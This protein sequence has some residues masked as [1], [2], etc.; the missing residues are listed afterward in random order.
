MSQTPS[1]HSNLLSASQN[2]IAAQTR[3]ILLVEDT[4]AHAALIKRAIDKKVWD[5]THVTRGEEAL[6]KYSDDRNCI[7]LLDI[8]LPDYDG[9]TL[10]SHFKSINPYAAVVIVT[11][12]EDVKE[13]V[14]A[15]KSGAW[16][17]VV[18]NDPETFTLDIQKAIDDAWHK[19]IE[20]AEKKLAEECSVAELIRS[21][22]E[23]AIEKT[24][25]KICDEINNPLSGLLTYGSILQSEKQSTECVEI[26]QKIME[27]AQKVANAVGKLEILTSESKQ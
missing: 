20:L 1:F 10:I 5:I 3:K 8:R 25:K 27:S 26:V 14:H 15:M 18:K 22:K 13:S 7:I 11:S 17:Y 4:A 2:L 16:N 6:A 9:I 19:R 24:I 21:E 12:L 23:N